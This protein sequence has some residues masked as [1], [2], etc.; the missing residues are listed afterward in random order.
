MITIIYS[1]PEVHSFQNISSTKKLR[2]RLRLTI[3]LLLLGI[4]LILYFPRFFNPFISYQI[5]LLAEQYGLSGIVIDEITVSWNQLIL[6]GLHVPNTN[7]FPNSLDDIYVESLT[8]QFSWKDL[9]KG[10]LQSCHV[11]PTTL[12]WLSNQTLSLFENILRSSGKK[13]DIQTLSFD[14]AKLE[15]L[16]P[17]DVQTIYFF[18]KGTIADHKT[19]LNFYY[20][21]YEDIIGQCSFCFED[22]FLDFEVTIPKIYYP[23]FHCKT[24]T[25]NISLKGRYHTQTHNISALFQ[26]TIHH[27][28]HDFLGELQKPLQ[29]HISLTGTLSELYCQADLL[30][31]SVVAHLEGIYYPYQTDLDFSL[32]IPS[33]QSIWQAN[34]YSQKLFLTSLNGSLQAKGKLVGNLNTLDG[35][36]DS[37]FNNINLTTPLFSLFNLNTHLYFDRLN[38]LI[39][40]NYQNITLEQIILGDVPLH[41]VQ[42]EYLFS[43]MGKFVI[44]N[45]QAE[46]LGKTAA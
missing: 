11:G 27:I 15:I 13:I 8:C 20:K 31:P 29:L 16:S 5:K 44:N 42:I 32:D 6:K 17:S 38:P 30:E 3:G 45:I 14:Q 41:N 40:R 1:M 9:I 37:H 24:Q 39:T 21:L 25:E 12:R 18:G 10:K 35:H 4:L 43:P 28:Q 33:L 34:P 7:L 46:S 2:S 22:Q 23:L 36:L 26:G 19:T